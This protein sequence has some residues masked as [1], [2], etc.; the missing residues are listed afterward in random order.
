MSGTPR[1]VVVHVMTVPESLAFLR[2]QAGY[3]RRRGFAVHAIASPGPPLATF[4]DAEGATVHAV[5]MTR[6][7][8]PL[9]DLRAL[10]D[11]WRTIRAIR[12]DVVHTHTPKGGCLG[13][14]AGWLTRTPVRV[15]HL[16][17]TPLV[18]ARGPKRVALWLGEWTSCRLAHRVIAVSHTLR[19]FAI[20]EGLCP[21]GK[22]TVL[23]SGSGNGVDAASRFRP[24]GEA[25]RRAA[26]EEL[27]IPAEA[28]VV[29]FVGRM[30]G[31]KGIVE[32]ARAWKAVRAHAPRA[33][34][35]FVGYPEQSSSLPAGLAERLREDP[36]V[37]FSGRVED[38]ARY[39]AAM[40]VV[41]LPTYREGF[42]NVALESAAMELP[43]VASAVPGCTDAI[44]D[45][46]TGTLV[47]VRDDAALAHALLR[48]LGS[49]ALRARHGAAGR[50]LVLAEFRPE[51]IWEAIAAEY[52]SLLGRAAV[53]EEASEVP[54]AASRSQG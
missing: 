25:V 52:E 34:L 15:Y 22:I 30:V 6:R 49:P 5:E 54:R 35:L 2:G 13:M 44:V 43:I 40:D 51:P 27:G 19:D 47:P 7:I 10:W 9:A 23:A 4:R 46:V 26:R 50:R 12:P 48:Y 45:G 36:R 39:Y 21:P 28:L 14:V 8:T 53:R 16:R 29:G 18:T 42:S 31:D 17:G 24:Q 3:V 20:R 37:H 33:R 32:L 1:P 41:A 11:V 38:P